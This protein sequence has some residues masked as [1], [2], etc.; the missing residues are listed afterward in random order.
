[1]RY[2]L[3]PRQQLQLG[4]YGNSNDRNGPYVPPQNHEVAPRDGG[5]NMA[6]VEDIMQKIIRR[7]DASDEYT[8]ELRNNL[9]GIGQKADTHVISIKHIELQIA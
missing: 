5:G 7:L 9:I 3:K 2:D 4:N 8:I 1:M 6:R